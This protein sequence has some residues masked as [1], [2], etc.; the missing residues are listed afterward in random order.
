MTSQKWSRLLAVLALTGALVACGDDDDGGTPD[1]GRADAGGG[2]DSGMVAED[3][4]GSDAGEEPDEDAGTDGGTV[5]DPEP[6]VVALSDTAHDR[7][8]A[9][10]F[11]ADGNVY[12]AGQIAV[13]ATDFALVVA[14]FDAEGELVA[15]FGDEGVATL[16]LAEGGAALENAY[17]VVVQP[18]AD[19]VVIAGEVEHDPAAAAP[20]NG[21]TD[22]VLVGFDTTTGDVDTDF[23]DEGIVRLDLSTGQVVGSTLNARDTVWS[24]SL[25]SE[26]RLVVHGT[27]RAAGL[28][29]EGEST[30]PTVPRT[31]S[32]FALVRLTADGDRDNTFSGDG[33]VTVDIVGDPVTNNVTFARRGAR[34]S[35]RSATVLADGSIIGTGYITSTALT[36]LATAPP[37]PPGESL[38]TSQQPVLYKVSSA[39]IFDPT[40]AATDET[41]LVGVW[42]DFAGRDERNA[43]AY[44]AALQGTNLVTIGYGPTVDATGMGTDWVSFRFTSAG[45]LDTTYGTGGQSY[46]DVGGWSDNGRAVIV[47][48][49]DR[50]LAVGGG[51]PD[52]ATAPPA[53][54]MPEVDAMVAVLQMGGA[55]DTTFGTNGARL[56]DLGATDFF[57]SVALSPDES[58]VAIA[59]IAGAETGGDD[60]AVLFLL[61]VD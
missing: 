51:R 31:D 35:A 49:D 8:R 36:E 21:D 44:G 38:R 40:F 52:P 47:L 42:H 2:T 48:G 3:D 45:V 29:P 39:G 27:Q 54:E 17:A 7:F 46:L 55:P 23:G 24:I 61:P 41:A 37:P 19:R 25:A 6:T 22:I 18:E 12:A 14:K 10:T 53:G 50:V 20:A 30:T 43:E 59:G 32:L 57:W 13:S 28:Q 1:A 11:D 4:A 60:D 33:L 9:V 58:T 16:N 5:P 26:E 34:A 15:E 56:Y